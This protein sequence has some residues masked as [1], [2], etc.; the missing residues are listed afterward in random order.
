MIQ[1]IGCSNDGSVWM[2]LLI[3]VNKEQLTAIIPMTAD[4][5]KEVRGALDIAIARGQ[6]WLETGVC[7]D[8]SP[9]IDKS[10]PKSDKRHSDR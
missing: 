1:E 7:P 2:S 5:A 9:R 10:K 3:E 4:K 8:D 6:K